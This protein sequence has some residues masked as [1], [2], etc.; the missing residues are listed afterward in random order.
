M[1]ILLVV[2]QA[3][4]ASAALDTGE[5]WRTA[6]LDEC[7][8]YSC[9]A[10][11]AINYNAWT[12]CHVTSLANSGA[13][14][15]RNC[16]SASNRWIVFDVTGT[17][18][19]TS[20]LVV[21][22]NTVIDG[23]GQQITIQGWGIDVVE[24]DNVIIENLIIDVT[25]LDGIEIRCGYSNHWIDHITFLRT[26]DEQGSDNFADDR[27]PNPK[28][29]ADTASV[30]SWNKWDIPTADCF[31]EHCYH[32]LLGSDTP[33]TNADSGSRYTVHHNWWIG[34]SNGGFED[35]RNPYTSQGH[36]HSFNNFLDLAAYGI[37]GGPNASVLSENDIFRGGNGT[38]RTVSVAPAGTGAFSIKVSG[39]YSVTG[40]ETYNQVNTGGIFTPPY[41]YTL[42]TAN[43][44]LRSQIEA[45]AGWQDVTAPTT[46]FVAITGPTSSPT[47]STGTT[48]LTTLAGSA[49][50]DVGVLSVAWAC[51]TCTPT[52]GA[53]SCVGCGASGTSI[54]WSVSSIGL[55]SGANV[56]T[57]TGTDVSGPGAGAVLTVTLTGPPDITSN[58]VA[59]YKFN[60]GAGTVTDSTV[61]AN[62]G[63]LVAGATY[64]T[65]A[66]GLGSGLVLNGTT[67]YVTVADANSLDLTTAYT[68]AAWV[69][70]TTASG[71]HTVMVKGAY[72]YYLYA[73]DTF[74][75]TAGVS[76]GHSAGSDAC[77]AT[78]LTANTWT[79]VAVTFA[80][81]TLTLYV[82]GV[83]VATATTSGP[84]VAGTG[85]LDLGH[86]PDGHFFSGTMDEV[87][88]YSRE[89]TSTDMTALVAFTDPV[90]TV[91][92][93]LRFVR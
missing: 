80:G 62:V 9:A 77:Y 86:S 88:I 82:N 76:A 57:V 44:A 29:D 14:T 4:P 83:S 50:D 61:N 65:G 28:G 79:H 11:Q 60:D 17:I 52:S 19:T 92:T 46:P 6:L 55:A 72:L 51:P 42:Q 74:C 67:Q 5:T 34:T 13:G 66:P 84:A 49:T 48:P 3:Q 87:R 15:L 71:N 20:G 58:L 24:T 30:W 31:S 8:G 45:G 68:L 73:T 7:M 85:S 78:G 93:A 2:V 64:G 25:T 10:L 27:C 1:V 21:L 39:Q 63:T 12:N 16:L 59:H 90:S 54:T 41:S 23:R 43:A 35:Q 56:I 26:G 91:P 89:L 38:P 36:C 32:L 18:T 47:Y 37:E 70:P 22:S 40:S 53:A 33:T 75:A 69:K 81:T